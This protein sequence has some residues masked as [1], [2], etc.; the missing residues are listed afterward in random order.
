[1]SAFLTTEKKVEIFKE[2]GGSEKNTGSVEAQIALFTER[3]QGMASHLKENN[4]DQS[5]RK[6][7]LTLVGKRKK[8][9]SYLQKK[10]LAS[11]RNLIQKLN[12]RK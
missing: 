9:L 1:M 7:L 10:D 8:L 3:I 5:C 12:I 6:G 2:F 4:K 11:Y